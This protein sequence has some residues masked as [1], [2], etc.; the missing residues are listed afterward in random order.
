M[1][2]KLPKGVA[3]GKDLGVI[4]MRQIAP[5]LAHILGVA[6]PTAQQKSAGDPVADTL[7]ADTPGERSGNGSSRDARG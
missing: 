3:H 5:T 6:L 7:A 4:D 1:S 2:T